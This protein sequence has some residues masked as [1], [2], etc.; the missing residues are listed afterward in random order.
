MKAACD[1][2]DSRDVEF[3]PDHVDMPEEL[4]EVDL[5]LLPEKEK[6]KILN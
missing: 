4:T 3:G 6:N 5:A 2:A 1:K